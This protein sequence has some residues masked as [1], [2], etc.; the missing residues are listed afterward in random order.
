MEIWA[1]YLEAENLVEWNGKNCSFKIATSIPTSISW[2]PRS[3]KS[4]DVR[5]QKPL[6]QIKYYLFLNKK[7]DV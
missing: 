5:E 4:S 1:E 3:K 7:R 6:T 2:S